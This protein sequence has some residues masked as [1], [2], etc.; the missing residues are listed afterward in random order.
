MPCEC[1]VCR[2]I[3]SA[4]LPVPS[5][6]TPTFVSSL[7]GNCFELLIPLEGLTLAADSGCCDINHLIPF[8]SFFLFQRTQKGI[9]QALTCLFLSRELGREWGCKV[10]NTVHGF[11]GMK[12]IGKQIMSWLP[13]NN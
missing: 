11:L 3:L 12:E 2:R 6:G 9:P 1:E 8:L 7:Q 4:S 13:N 10:I 5:L